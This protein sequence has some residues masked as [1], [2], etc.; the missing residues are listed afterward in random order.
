[1]SEELAEL[2]GCEPPPS[3]AALPEPARE[4]LARLIGSARAQQGRDLDVAFAAVIKGVPFPVRPIARR[5]LGA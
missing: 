4:Q 5:I 1:M 3:V 2:L